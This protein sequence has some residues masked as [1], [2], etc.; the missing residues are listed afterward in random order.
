ML[1][2][3]LLVYLIVHTVVGPLIDAQAVLP[4]AFPSLGSF[5]ENAGL[6]HV[7][8]SWCADHGDFLMAERPVWFKAAVWAEIMLQVP[9]CAVL[10]LGWARRQEWVRLPSIMYSVHV[11]TTMV[12]I[13]AVLL[14]EGAARASPPSAVCIGAYAVWVALPALLLWRCMTAGERLF[15]RAKDP[16]LK[17]A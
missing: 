9:T 8:S 17:G 6:A 11:L 13:M 10:S 3:L 5:Y 2:A 1:D 14:I 16:T 4:D 15:E 12:P 7:V